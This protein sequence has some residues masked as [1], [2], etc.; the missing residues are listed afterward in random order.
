MVSQISTFS[1]ICVF[2][3]LSQ[4]SKCM[5]FIQ[6]T[7]IWHFY[8]FTIIYRLGYKVPTLWR[9]Y[10]GAFNGDKP[11]PKS[12]NLWN[13]PLATKSWK[14]YQQP[15]PKIFKE[16]SLQLCSVTMVKQETPIY[17][18]N[19]H[20]NCRKITRTHLHMFA[21]SLD[22]LNEMLDNFIIHFIAQHS[23]VLNS[24]P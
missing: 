1:K 2:L 20:Q 11:L 8:K 22:T 19:R 14:Q 6:L 18:L 5:I 16:S 13:H 12:R 17:L 24:N 7:T 10:L 21:M 15:S 23:I 3:S 4:M 9:I